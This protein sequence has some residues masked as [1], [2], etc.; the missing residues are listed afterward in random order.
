MK[1]L[2]IWVRNFFELP[3]WYEDEITDMLRFREEISRTTTFL[4]SRR[5]E[6][7]KLNLHRPDLESALDKRL[8]Q[9]F[10]KESFLVEMLEAYNFGKEKQS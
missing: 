3:F 7:V 10:K 1:K 2:L 8:T 6:L 4:L 5:R 9:A